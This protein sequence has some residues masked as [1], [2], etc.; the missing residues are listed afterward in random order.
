MPYKLQSPMG[1]V[2]RATEDHEVIRVTYHLESCLSHEVVQRVQVD[3]AEQRTENRALRRASLGGP[4]G[5]TIKNARFQEG[6]DQRQHAAIGDSFFQASHQAVVRNRVEVAFQVG[7][8]DVDVS[9]L[10]QLI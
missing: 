3:V 10:Q 7:V 9:R 1:L 5:Q 8:H 4:R 6:F 2:C